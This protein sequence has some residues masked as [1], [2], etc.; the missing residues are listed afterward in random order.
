M[1]NEPSTLS[2]IRAEG[3]E[4]GGGEANTYPRGMTNPDL[5]RFAENID[6]MKQLAKKNGSIH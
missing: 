2:S 6:Q 4:G 1:K 5:K 3:V